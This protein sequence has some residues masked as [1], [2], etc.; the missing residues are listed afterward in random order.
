MPLRPLE[1]ALNQA[2]S[3]DADS[4]AKLHQFEQRS[5]HL[6]ITDFQV[7]IFI[8][9]K[10]ASLKLA[11]GRDK[12]ADLMI[13]ADSAALIKVARNPDN[14]FSAQIKILGDVQFAKQLQDWLNGFDFDWEA[15]LAKVT[16]DTL[17]YPIAQGLRQGF[18]WLNSSADSF[19]K[20]LAEYLREESRLLP[21]KAETDRFMQDIDSLQAAADR[22]EA[23]IQ[24]LQKKHPQDKA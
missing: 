19:Q 17:A 6:D 3:A 1:F 4:Q 15:Q 9:F 12:T 8:Q 18:G 14:L 24:R 13:A 22:L 23:R 16:G 5:I 10:N 2:L 21:D 11:D 7:S 20:S